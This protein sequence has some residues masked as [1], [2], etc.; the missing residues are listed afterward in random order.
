MYANAKI[1]Q[2]V[3]GQELEAT[4]KEAKDG[5]ST[6]K[7]FSLRRLFSVMSGTIKEDARYHE[8]Y[9]KN[10]PAIK[11]VIDSEK[12]IAESVK[13][14]EERAKK[15]KAIEQKAVALHAQD[16]AAAVKFLNNYSNEKAQQM[17]DRWNQLAQYLIVKYNDMVEKQEENGTYKRTKYGLPIVKR[18]GFPTP[19][20][21]HYVK[22][23]G[24]KY[25]IP[26]ND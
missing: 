7:F 22:M 4:D 26:Q 9:L 1:L 25:A 11:P 10:Y 14:L 8:V 2:K 23:T 16:E 15:Q 19:Y 24:D 3:T 13:K 17:L 21:R 12:R 20:A 5:R 6:L 18:P